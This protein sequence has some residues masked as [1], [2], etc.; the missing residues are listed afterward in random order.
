MQD[1]IL[2]KVKDGKNLFVT[3]GAG[4]GKTFTSNKIIDMFYNSSKKLAVCAMTGLASQHLSFGQTIQR[5]AL[6]GGYTSVSDFENLIGSKF[7]NKLNRQ[8]ADVDSIMIDEIS[9]MRPDY[10]HLLDKVLRHVM[11]LHYEQSGNHLLPFGGKQIIAVGDFLQLPPVVMREENMLLNYAFET[12]AWSDA[13]FSVAL[14]TEVKRQNDMPFIET[15]NKFRVGFVDKEAADMMRSREEIKQEHRPIMLMSKIKKVEAFNNEMLKLH[16]GKEEALSGIIKVGKHLEGRDDII[17]M[18]YREVLAEAGLNK[19]IFVKTG[20]RVMCLA[21]DPIMDISNGMLGT[22]IGFKCFDEH[23]YSYT[24]E[25]GEVHDLDYK[26]FGE[27]LEVE[28]DDGRRR[29]ITRKEFNVKNREGYTNDK[30]GEP[31]NDIQYWQYPVAVGYAI[32]IHKSQ[33]MSLDSVHVDCSGIFAEG[34]LY[35]GVSRARSLEGLSVSNFT[36]G[37]V[38]ANQKAVD[39]YMN[40]MGV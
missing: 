25:K 32:S 12:K 22:L 10:I 14:L 33:G 8:I 35:V 3:G 36:S 13:K 16:D 18:R 11:W 38:M 9:M 24:D 5:F 37:Y 23:N 29:I 2:Q 28:F 15:L 20:C 19:E 40:L 6:T 7:F 34:Q 31:L 39:Y 21:N 17:R 27:C 1:K 4:V 30:S 26:Y